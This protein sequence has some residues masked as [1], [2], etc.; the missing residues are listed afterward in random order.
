[1]RRV[2]GTLRTALP[3]R[4]A[5]AVTLA[6]LSLG[7]ALPA[8]AGASTASVTKIYEECANGTVP[9]GHS[10]QE[11]N[12]ALRE[13]EPFLAEYSACPDLIRK[14]QLAGA[15]RSGGGAA[16]GPGAASAPSVAAPTPTEQRTLES[17]PRRGAP[18]VPVGDEVIHPGV[19][20]VNLASAFSALPTPL[21]VLLAFLVACALLLGGRTARTYLRARRI[22]S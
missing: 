3:R 17:I 7:V 14:A 2:F 1:M 18:S 19:V 8:G 11:Y 5:L 9:S 10:Q 20:H 13:L 12:Q 16:G 21:L 22:D 15:A 4:G 6:L